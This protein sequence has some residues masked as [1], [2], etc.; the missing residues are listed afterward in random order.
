VREF[1][2]DASFTLHWCFEDEATDA[3][4]SILTLLQNQEALA[5]VPTIWQYEILNGLGKGVTRGRIDRQKAFLL[6]QEIRELPVLVVDAP[7]N[8]NS[9]SW[10]WRPTS[11]CTTQAT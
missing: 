7:I 6:W 2:L 4:E 8:L 3:T 9:W 11:P 10:L 1:V 5:W